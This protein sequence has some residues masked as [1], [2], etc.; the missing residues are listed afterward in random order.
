MVER[1]VGIVIL[2][3]DKKYRFFLSYQLNLSIST[4]FLRFCFI[5]VKI[6]K[7]LLSSLFKIKIFYSFKDLIKPSNSLKF[8]KV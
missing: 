1:F 8:L 7:I 6:V 2:K 4:K 3:S 5:F